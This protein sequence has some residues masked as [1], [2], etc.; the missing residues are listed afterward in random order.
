M[1]PCVV[2]CFQ[3]YIGLNRHSLK[4]SNLFCSLLWDSL[5]ICFPMAL[6]SGFFLS[7]TGSYINAEWILLSYLKSVWWK[8]WMAIKITFSGGHSIILLAAC[9]CGVRNQYCR[10]GGKKQSTRQWG[11]K[12]EKPQSKLGVGACLC[13]IIKQPNFETSKNP[14]SLKA[15]ASHCQ[16]QIIGCK[17]NI[18]YSYLWWLF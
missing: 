14:G 13:W 17:E 5:K 12:K 6:R 16:I 3:Y 1:W 15:S 7:F 9:L 4:T 2:S 18:C 11:G 10:F 8:F